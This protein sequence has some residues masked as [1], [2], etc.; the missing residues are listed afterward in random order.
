MTGKMRRQ[1]SKKKK[2]FNWFILYIAVLVLFTAYVLADTFLIARPLAA[3]AADETD[4]SADITDAAAAITDDSYSDGSITVSIETLRLY[5]TD[6]YVA[7]V[8]L[9]DINCLQTAF[10][11]NT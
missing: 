11:N 2:R 8:T 3:A 9:A 1:M 6:I 4:E 5:D 10:A 7:R